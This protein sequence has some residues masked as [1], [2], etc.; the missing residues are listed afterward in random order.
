M[1]PNPLNAYRQVRVKTATQDKLIV[2]LYDEGLKQ[3]Q[4]AKKEL[5]EQQ[6]DLESVHNAI[7]KAQDVITELMVSLNFDQG[8][9]IAQ[10]LFH[11]Y[12]YFNQ[13]LVEANISKNPEGVLHIYELMNELREAWNTIEGTVKQQERDVTSGINLA[14]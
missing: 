3:L 5:S 10:N 6:P 2:M 8:G 4:Y 7:V 1:I 12:M 9:K 11:L 14:G 13:T